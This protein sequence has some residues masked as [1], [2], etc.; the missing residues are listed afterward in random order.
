MV[1]P[2]APREGIVWHND[3]IVPGL[4][5]ASLS[6]DGSIRYV[7]LLRC[8]VLEGASLERTLRDARSVCPCGPGLDRTGHSKRERHGGFNCEGR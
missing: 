1:R 8:D 3:C 4:A 5:G 7:V 6:L 2:V